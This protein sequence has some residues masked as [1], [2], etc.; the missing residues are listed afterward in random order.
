MKVRS[1]KCESPHRSIMGKYEVTQAQWQVVMGSTPS[2]FK[3]D[4]LPVEQVSWDDC[5]AFCRKLNARLKRV[6]SRFRVRLPSE[7]E[8][9]YACRAGSSTRFSF[10]DSDGALAN[11]AWYT[12]N[13]SRTRSVGQK[14][15]N[16]WGLYDMHGNVW[17]W[18]E[19]VY[20][21][22]YGRAPGDGSA[23]TTYGEGLRM[24]RGGSWYSV[25][26]LCRTAQ[27][28][29]SAPGNRDSVIGFRVVAGIP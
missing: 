4:N 25:A 6:G 21:E 28:G 10:G 26:N 16:A 19:D 24:F 8:W 29:W 7:A 20:N 14:R 1:T 17:E 11:Y 9:E 22:S 27:R 13:S 12:E 3:G 23:S 5:Q 18:C 15:A 2:H